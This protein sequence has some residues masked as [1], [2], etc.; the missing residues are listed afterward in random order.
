[1]VVN[2]ID[3][4]DISVVVQGAVDAVNTPKCLASIRKYLPGAEIIL[5]TWEG[6]KVED[7]DFDK[8]LLN[9]DPGG[10]PDKRQLGFTNNTLRQ[11]LSSKSGVRK[12][13]RPYLLKMRTDLILNSNRFLSFFGA[14][15]VRNPEYQLFESRI[16]ASSFFSKKFCSSE[17]EDMPLPFHLSDWFVFGKVADIQ[18]LYDIPLPIEPDNSWY[19]NKRVIAEHPKI[20]LLQSSH[21]Y[22][23]E[24]YIFYFACKKKFTQIEFDHYLDYDRVNI[25]WSERLIANNCIILDPEQFAFI[26][27]KKSTGTDYYKRWT[28]NSKS[29][30]KTLKKGLYTYRVFCEDYQKYCLPGKE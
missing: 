25:D 30:P 22:A 16:I 15:P 24:Q 20:D 28:Q 2:G 14:F 27:G 12:S 10:I 23:P 3:T 9:K 18:A 21:R 4:K 7:L 8:V 1:M 17:T 5:S 26:C 11:V 29:I 6:T 13:E 19:V